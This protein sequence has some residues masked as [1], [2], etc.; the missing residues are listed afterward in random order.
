LVLDSPCIFQ[1]DTT[2]ATF[3]ICQFSASIGVDIIFS[4][5]DI[6]DANCQEERGKIKKVRNFKGGLGKRINAVEKSIRSEKKEREESRP[7]MNI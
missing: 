4:G 5:M 3:G 7:D 1:P 2:A 6:V